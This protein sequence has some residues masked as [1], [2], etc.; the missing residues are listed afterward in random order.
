M[1]ELHLGKALTHQIGCA[2][3]GAI[4]HDDL[5]VEA[6]SRDADGP[7]ARFN[8]RLATRYRVEVSLVDATGRETIPAKYN[9]AT[10]LRATIKAGQLNV[11][12]FDVKIDG[13]K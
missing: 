10:E 7:E 5:A 3:R 4:H 8:D 1:D 2:V 12:D 13:K 6:W 9:T 11:H